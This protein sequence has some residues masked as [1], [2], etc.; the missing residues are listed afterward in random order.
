MFRSKHSY[1]RNL[2]YE[3]IHGLRHQDVQ[4]SCSCNYNS[5]TWQINGPRNLIWICDSQK[6][7]GKLVCYI[8]MMYTVKTSL[9]LILNY[10]W[11]NK[12]MPSD[13]HEQHFHSQIFAFSRLTQIET[14]GEGRGAFF[15]FG[16]VGGGGLK[17]VG[18]GCWF[19]RLF[20]SVS[21]SK[22]QEKETLQGVT[23]VLVNVG[24]P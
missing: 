22:G 2:V 15:N 11:L 21:S 20:Q 12:V 19:V 10:R 4:R 9:S 24:E 7:K 14:E 23:F 1:H 17:R 3:F 8:V 5:D 18:R 6:S 13:Q 16:L